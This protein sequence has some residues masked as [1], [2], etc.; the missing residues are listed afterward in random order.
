MVYKRLGELLIAAEY[1]TP[2]Q[3]NKALEIQ[4][5]VPGKK[6]G[7]ILVEQGFTTQRRVYKMLERQLGVEFIDLTG[8]AISKEMTRIVPRS[9]ARK[10]NV[11]PVQATRETLS[12]A[13]ADPLN[14][15]ATDAVKMVAKRKVVPML[16]TAEAITRTITDLYGSESAEKALQDLKSTEDQP[17]PTSRTSPPPTSSAPIPKMQPP[18]SVWSTASWNTLST[19]TAPIFTWSPVRAPCLSACVST[20]CCGRFSWFPRIPRARSLPVS[21]SWAT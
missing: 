18:P 6:L 15:V 3:L 11:V 19:R 17:P 16:A 13:M 9:I 1:I 5:K 14:F 8:M 10:Y 7:E 12:L 21:R 2:E 20:V 4:K